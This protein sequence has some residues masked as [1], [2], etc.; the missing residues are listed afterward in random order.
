MP[1]STFIKNGAGKSKMN[2]KYKYNHFLK[3]LTF[4]EA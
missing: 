4:K 1:G 3:M 2:E